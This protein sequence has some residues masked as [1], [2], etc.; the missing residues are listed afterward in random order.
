MYVTCAAHLGSG[1]PPSEDSG[2][3]GSCVGQSSCGDGAEEQPTEGKGRAGDQSYRRTLEGLE[4]GMAGE[5]RSFPA[6][7]GR[8]LGGSGPQEGLH[9]QE[10]R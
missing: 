7:W 6:L 3:G 10:G 1:Q 4:E 2:A 5:P 8:L 9:L